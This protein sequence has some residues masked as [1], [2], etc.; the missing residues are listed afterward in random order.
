MIVNETSVEIEIITHR[1]AYA[2]KKIYIYLHCLFAF[3]FSVRNLPFVCIFLF[4]YDLESL[5]PLLLLLLVRILRFL[6]RFFVVV[7]IFIV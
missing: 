3:I 2:E 4:T 5:L 7:F 1:I 6:L